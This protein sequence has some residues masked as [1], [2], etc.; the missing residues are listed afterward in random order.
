LPEWRRLPFDLLQAIL[1]IGVAESDVGVNGRLRDRLIVAN[2]Q[3]DLILRFISPD[4]QPNV[5]GIEVGEGIQVII[6]G[7]S[8]RIPQAG[9]PREWPDDVDALPK[10]PDSQGLTK[11]RV[12]PL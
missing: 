3:G 8:Y 9:R 1:N 6:T 2:P 10:S 11:I 5:P 12:L 7:D 4:S